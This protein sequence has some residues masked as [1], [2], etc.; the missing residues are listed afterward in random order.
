MPEH[1]AL[2]GTIAKVGP[3][4]SSKIDRLKLVFTT[5]EDT[6][7]LSNTSDVVL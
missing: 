2:L 1:L 7:H 6:K 4:K 3:G 5:I